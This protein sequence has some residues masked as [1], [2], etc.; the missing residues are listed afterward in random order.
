MLPCLLDLSVDFCRTSA[1][2]GIDVATVKANKEA[3]F[4]NCGAQVTILE[5]GTKN[6]CS[7]IRQQVK[8][9]VSLDTAGPGMGHTIQACF[10]ECM[11]LA[12]MMVP[13]VLDSDM[14]C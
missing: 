7:F 4:K 5:T 13:V 6:G 10:Y 14:W 3:M 12:E 11:H 8:N 1:Y 9:E 2:K